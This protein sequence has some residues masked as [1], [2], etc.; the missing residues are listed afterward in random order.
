MEELEMKKEGEKCPNDDMYFGPRTKLVQINFY[1]PR[2][3][4]EKF[5]SYFGLIDERM[6]YFDKL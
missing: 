1:L 5:P 3:I 2:L 6:N 4:P